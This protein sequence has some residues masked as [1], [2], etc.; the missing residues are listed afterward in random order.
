[1]NLHD[2]KPGYKPRNINVLSVNVDHNGM[3]VISPEV[4]LKGF[5]KCCISYALNETTD[6]YCGKAVKRMGMLGVCV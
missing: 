3:A 6:T 4:T 1:V 5:Q 2:F